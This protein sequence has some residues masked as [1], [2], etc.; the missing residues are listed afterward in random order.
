MTKK[1]KLDELSSLASNMRSRLKTAL[2]HHR[3]GWNPSCRVLSLRYRTGGDGFGLEMT[4]NR[5]GNRQRHMFRL[6]VRWFYP[7]DQLPEMD[8]LKKF[9]WGGRG[10][11]E[12]SAMSGILGDLPHAPQEIDSLL[13]LVWASY[14]LAHPDSLV[15][16]VGE[17]EFRRNRKPTSAHLPG[18]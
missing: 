1:V 4:L 2:R 11:S 10:W 18:F 12:A 6:W 9:M 13:P 8:Q 17:D 3:G 15:R 7:Y 5:Q 16:L 14:R